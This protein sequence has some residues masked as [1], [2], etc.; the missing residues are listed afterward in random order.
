[1]L[2]Y[3][4]WIYKHTKPARESTGLHC[5]NFLLKIKYSDFDFHNFLV[6]QLSLSSPTNT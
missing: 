5:V 1:M 4:L 3:I 2:K 6:C